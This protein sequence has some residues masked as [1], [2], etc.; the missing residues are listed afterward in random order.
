MRI[1]LTAAQAQQAVRGYLAEPGDEGT[2]AV[3]IPDTVSIAVSSGRNGD[4][5]VYTGQD[6]PKAKVKSGPKEAA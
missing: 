5:I 3:M 6:V 1:K 2:E 4:L